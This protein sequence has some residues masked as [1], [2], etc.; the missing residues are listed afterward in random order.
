ML[1]AIFFFHL[2]Y[3]SCCPFCRLFSSIARRGRTTLPPLATPLQTLRG[4]NKEFQNVGE[5]GTYTSY[6]R[7][8]TRKPKRRKKIFASELRYI[9][10]LTLIYTNKPWSMKIRCCWRLESFEDS[11]LQQ[12]RWENLHMPQ[13]PRHGADCGTS[14][15]AS[16]TRGTDCGSLR[17]TT[18]MD[19]C[20]AW[21]VCLKLTLQYCSVPGRTAFDGASRPNG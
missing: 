16:G 2:K 9:D 17:N 4:K 3:A 13:R 20:A 7:A 14:N 19:T 1:R 12:H 5:S 6:H 18:C 21:F 15:S 11:N 8:L 10:E